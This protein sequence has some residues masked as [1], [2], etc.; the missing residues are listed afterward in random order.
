MY[1]CSPRFHHLVYL[2]CFLTRRSHTQGVNILTFL[3]AVADSFLSYIQQDSL[4]LQSVYQ[5]ALVDALFFVSLARVHNPKIGL[6]CARAVSHQEYHYGHTSYQFFQYWNQTCSSLLIETRVELLFH[7][8]RYCP[9]ET[10]K[11]DQRK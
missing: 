1:M 9:V 11:D 3:V 10:R 4:L 8:S 5:H 2:Y 7:L 6:A